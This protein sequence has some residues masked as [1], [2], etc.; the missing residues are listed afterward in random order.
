M[1]TTGQNDN[2]TDNSGTLSQRIV[3]DCAALCVENAQK[4]IALIVDECSPSPHLD[5]S[6]RGSAASA[7]AE[8]NSGTSCGSGIIPWW[9]RVFYLHV[10]GTVLMAATLQP[11]LCTSAVSESWGRAMAALR[12]HEHLSPFVAQCL[13]TFETLSSGMSTHQQTPY[14]PSVAGERVAHN[15]VNSAPMPPLQDVFFQDMAYETEALFFG[16]D[17][18]SWMGNL[19]LPL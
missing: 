15:N 1:P 8:S 2:T 11:N 5:G 13:A 3:Q 17:D 14:G 18:T 9:Y 6:G 19:A 10:A 7:D 16:M 4:V 12:A